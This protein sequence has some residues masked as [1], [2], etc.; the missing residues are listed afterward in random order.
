MKPAAP[1][2]RG[3]FPPEL[4]QKIRDSVSILEVVGEHVV[5]RKAGANYTG[6]CPFHNERSPSFSV[7]EQKQLYHCY[8]C[9]KGGDIVGFIMDLHGSS[10][11]EAIQDLAERG[12]VKIPSGF[13]AD[14]DDPE[15][16]KRKAAQRDRW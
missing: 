15:A 11:M 1:P 10:F 2:S 7:S 13:G 9:K 3:R 12:K 14:P 6:L 4:I 16:A 8:G 5:L